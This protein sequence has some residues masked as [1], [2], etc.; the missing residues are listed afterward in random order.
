MNAT[1][2]RDPKPEPR[3][4]GPITIPVLPCVSLPEMLV[5]YGHLGFEVT[6]QQRSPNPYGATRRGDVHLHFMGIARLDPAK[7]FT[8]CLVLVP[9]VEALHRT[10]A[11]GLRSAYGR[12]P[13]SGLPRISRL[14]PGATRFTLTDLGG[15][16]VI[17]IRPGEQG[18]NDGDAPAPTT[19]LGRALLTAARLRDFK[20]DDTAAGRLLDAAL[21]KPDGGT[22][23]ERGRA[24]LAR[25]EIAVALGDAERAR[26]LRAESDAL[27][28]SPEEQRALRA[29]REALD[30]LERAPA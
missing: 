14:R 9:E 7:N 12:V 2:S 6:Y 21:R 4:P 18:Y 28:L 17:F 20:H 25:A 23:L 11:D 13:V 27:S 1:P 22:A 19:A 3:A 29:D 26:A 16:S 24:L 5:F 30:A 8:T 15:N 10:F